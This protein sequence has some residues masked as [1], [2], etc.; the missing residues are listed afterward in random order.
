MRF[1]LFLLPSIALAAFSPDG[2]T[3]GAVKRGIADLTCNV[4]S[5]LNANP[6]SMVSSVGNIVVGICAVTL[7]SGYFSAAPYCRCSRSIASGTDIVVA[8]ES[9]SATNLDVQTLDDAGAF[10]GSAVTIACTGAP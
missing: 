1:L 2:A 4:T 9:T 8:C 6:D 5:T 3:I 7:S 10:T